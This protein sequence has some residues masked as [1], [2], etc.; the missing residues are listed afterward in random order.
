[1]ASDLARQ[2]LI[3][4]REAGD[5]QK[6]EEARQ[7]LT[8]LDLEAERIRLLNLRKNKSM[9]SFQKNMKMFNNKFKTN[10]DH[11]HLKKH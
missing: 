5:Y 1:M 11:N 2:N 8:K 3:A 6:E 9:N 10:Q 4:A 7:A